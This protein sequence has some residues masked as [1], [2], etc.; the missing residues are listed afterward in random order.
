MAGLFYLVLGVVA[1][2]LAAYVFVSTPAARIVALGRTFVV[3]ALA[4]VALGLFVAG[5]SGLAMMLGTAALGLFL[6]GRAAGTLGTTAGR[7]SRV[8]SAALEMELDHD[9]GAMSG[10]VLSGTFFDRRLESLDLEELMVLR[11]E[12][13]DD[14]E[15]RQLLDAYLDRLHPRWRDDMDADAGAG[16]GGTPG[17]GAMTEKEAYEIL[18]LDPGA[19]AAEIRKAH[20]RLMQRVHPD[21]GGSP[22]LAARIN[23]AKDFLLSGHD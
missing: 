1:L 3:I 15:S 4:L 2:V 11:G 16:L 19:G 10:L 8:R 18:G 20:R 14:E 6:R 22:F 5:R 7:R 21:V 23:A 12:L 9:T 13:V 17:A